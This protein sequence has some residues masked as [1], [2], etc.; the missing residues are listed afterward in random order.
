M[1]EHKIAF[2]S[3]FFFNH[4][5]FDLVLFDNFPLTKS[6]ICLQTMLACFS[7]LS[8]P[9]FSRVLRDSTPRLVGPSVHPL[10][11]RSVTLYFFGVSAVY[12]VTAPAQFLK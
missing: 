11:C 2:V 10:V 9:V 1:F 12:G 3:F 8:R 5:C 6:V 4:F 7:T